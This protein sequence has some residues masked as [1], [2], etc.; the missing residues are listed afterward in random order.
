MTVQC[1]SPVCPL[2][3]FH[4]FSSKPA[5]HCR[6][7]C[8]AVDFGQEPTLLPRY[9]LGMTCNCCVTMMLSHTRSQGKLQG[10]HAALTLWRDDF[11]HLTSRA[12]WHRC[13]ISIFGVSLI[14]CSVSKSG[15]SPSAVRW[16]PPG[17][18]FVSWGLGLKSY[19]HSAFIIAA[20]WLSAGNPL[21]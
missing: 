9:R 19:L 17:F 14:F 10:E 12:S 13:P 16:T 15:Q 7:Y 6:D 20:L 8:R 4:W 5:A 1:L 11:I 18:M 21:K 3:W 2:I